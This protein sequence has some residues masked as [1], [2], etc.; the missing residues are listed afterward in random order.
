M[1]KV[2][3]FCVFLTMGLLLHAQSV[4]VAGLVKDAFTGNPV[5]TGVVIH[6]ENPSVG[7]AI[8]LNGQFSLKLAVGQQTLIFQS[9]GYEDLERSVLVGKNGVNIEVSMIQVS[10]KELVVTAD[11][12]L[13]RKVPVAY[14]NIPLKRLEEELAG[15]EMATLANTTPGTYATRAGGGDGDARVTIRGFSGNNVAVMLDGVP[16]NDMENGTVY[17]SNWFGLDL[18]TQTSQIQRGLG[19]SKLV[20]PAVGGTMNIITRGIE[21]KRRVQI[22]QEYAY[23]AFAR[24]SV[25][26]NSGKFG[27]DWAISAALSFKNGDGWVD[28]TFTKGFF[29]FM[30]VE[31]KVNKHMLSFYALAA[32]QSHGQRMRTEAIALYDRP[33]ALS[34]GA[35]TT[36]YANSANPDVAIPDMGINYNPDVGYLSRYSFVNGAKTDVQDQ[37]LFNARVNYFVKPQFSLKDVWTIDEKSFLSTVL[38]ASMGN[39]GGTRWNTVPGATKYNP[40]GTVDVQSYYDENIGAKPPLFSGPN[41]NINPQVSATERYAVSNYIK[42]SVNQH[43]WIGGLSTYNHKINDRFSYSVGLDARYYVGRHFRQVYDLLGADYLIAREN[44]NAN[45][46]SLVKHVGDKIDYWNDARIRWAGLFGQ[47]EYEHEG[48]AAFLSGSVAGTGYQRIDYFLPKVVTADDGTPIYVG[49][50]YDILNSSP[51]ALV[52]D[53]TTYNGTQY[54]SGDARGEYQKTDW[55]Y[56]PTFTM[57]GGVKF[58]LSEELTFFQNTGYLDKAPLFNQVFTNSN[59]RF[60]RIFN[61]KILSNEMGL[62]WKN[63]RL[64]W[65]ANVYY[66]VWQ[67]KPYPYGLSVPNPVDPSTNITI[68]VQGM[69]ARHTGVEFDM[70]YKFDDHWTVEALASYG[71]W[72]WTSKQTIFVYDDQNRPVPADPSDPS[73]GQYTVNFDA[74]GVHVS[75]A[76]QSQL[77]GMVRYETSKG[78]YVKSRYTWFDRYFA[79]FNPF[80]LNGTNAGR[81]SWQ[82]P[83]YG[84]L[85]LHAG[86]PYQYK[87]VKFD[88]RVSVFNVLN[89]HFITDA[90]TNDTYAMYNQK[91]PYDFG[92]GSAGV[93]FGQG[94]WFNVSLT[95]TF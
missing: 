87:A 4:E 49:Y 24:T 18:V 35:P 3:S 54:V 32:P 77:G 41:Y 92:A 78:I 26:Y 64:A 28:G 63:K 73:K 94:R 21:Q 12:A 22:R 72:I 19:A 1:K 47:L 95:A 46:S 51:I 16:V 13:D 8:D 68:N 31:K 45:E 83:S 89:S 70:A 84:T 60:A 27:K 25:G 88:F 40:D 90:T 30:K 79:E 69:N 34:L 66:T 75:D 29:G 80:T 10:Q 59:A 67:N 62:N 36:Y 56:R 52:S 91:N 23:G 14:S 61:E 86:V 71:D 65:N 39:G 5:S 33:T 93:Y 74:R 9:V 17:W 53:T 85:E 2:V 6:K 15:R 58:P 55:Y 42:T 50:S 76:A 20:I 37:A 57:K 81:E 43:M 11:L 38:Y 48:I 44:F 7:C 82:I